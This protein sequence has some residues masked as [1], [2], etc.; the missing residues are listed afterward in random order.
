MLRDLAPSPH[1][2][3]PIVRTLLLS[4]PLA[5]PASAWAERMPAPE[6]IELSELPLRAEEN[7]LTPDPMR[8][9]AP[10]PVPFLAADATDEE[11]AAVPEDAGDVV[12]GRQGKGPWKLFEGTFAEDRCR[13]PRLSDD[14]SVALALCAGMD[15]SR[16][17]D[18]HVVI[19]R[20][21]ELMRYRAA[22]AP[23][24]GGASIDLSPDGSRFAVV[25]EEGGG[26]RSIHLVNLDKKVDVRLSGGWTDPGNAVVSADAEAV[27]FEAQVGRDRAIVVVH[28]EDGRAVVVERAPTDAR[29]YG[30]DRKGRR[31]LFTTKVHGSQLLKVVDIDRA[32]SMY[33]SST[34]NDVTGAWMDQDIDSVFYSSRIGGL[35]ALYWG[36]ATSRRRIELFSDLETCPR[37]TGMDDAG[38]TVLFATMRGRQT[39]GWKLYDRKTREARY[40]VIEGCVDPYLSGSG[41]LMAVRCPTARAGEGV[42]LFR[43]PESDE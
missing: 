18:E 4:V 14:G 38:R 31:V 37:V 10:W 16:P 15:V 11:K 3:I 41:T 7:P 24:P 23:L 1:R 6:K 28:M 13:A 35:C 40:E 9:A 22:A 33:V 32:T 17:E 21:G 30:L 34:K 25:V 26:G 12:P 2:S 36:N 29:V 43:I 5:L 20:N 42:Y 27:A 39:L 19:V 8:R